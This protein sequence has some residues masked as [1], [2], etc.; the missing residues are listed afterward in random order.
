MAEDKGVM[1]PGER[2]LTS[3]GSFVAVD[4]MI[5][6]NTAEK[7]GMGTK[8]YELI[9][10]PQPEDPLPFLP[11]IVPAGMTLRKYYAVQHVLPKGGFKR[12]DEVNLE[13]VRG[14][15][16]GVHGKAHKSETV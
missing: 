5:Q 4:E 7:I 13:E 11:S 12:E 6:P 3:C 16:A 2:K 15:D 9:E 10:V 8:E 14:N 1:E